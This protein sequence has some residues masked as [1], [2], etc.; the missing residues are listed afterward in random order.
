[1]T[2]LEVRISPGLGDASQAGGDPAGHAANVVGTDVDLAGVNP[3]PDRVSRRG[4]QGG[5]ATDR[6]HRTVECG[7]KPLVRALD[8][9]AAMSLDAAARGVL[10]NI[11]RAGGAQDRGQHAVW[12]RL[13]AG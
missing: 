5:G 4:A 3:D 2:I 1:M 8:P 9:A 7:E 12:L 13:G 10:V 11:E 6:A